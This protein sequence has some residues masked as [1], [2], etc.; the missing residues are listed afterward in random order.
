MQSVATKK[1]Q[2]DNNVAIFEHRITAQLAGFVN[3]G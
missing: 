1:C 2:N 3:M